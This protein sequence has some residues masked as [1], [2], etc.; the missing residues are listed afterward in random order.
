MRAEFVTAAQKIMAQ[1]EKTIFISGDLGFNAFEGLCKTFGPRF[2]NAGVAEQNMVGM[3]AGM[4]LEGF[5]PWAYS[6]APFVTYRCVEQIRNDVCLHNLPVRLAGNG[7]GYTYGIMGSTHHTMEDMAVLKALP[8]MTLYFPCTNN[9]V[10]AAVN[11]SA[12]LI[13][14]SYMRLGFCGFGSNA[15]ALEEN[16]TTLTRMY[17]TGEKVTVIGIGQATQ[18]ALKAMEENLLKKADVALFGLAK[19]PFD[20]KADHKLMTSINR[21]G[22]ILVVEE[23]YLYGSIA[24]SLKMALPPM[25]KFE[26]ITP[27]YDLGHTY[28]SPTFHLKQAGLT[29][30]HLAEVAAQLST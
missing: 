8:N 15:T 6:I 19:F 29:P 16:P 28:G 23:H 30:A 12:K 9:H 20:L 13:G 4:A 18:V 2:L 27:A 26:V 10:E 17:S 5:R 25:E 1:D 7:G 21:T 14:P 24:E 3:A 11:Q 22:R